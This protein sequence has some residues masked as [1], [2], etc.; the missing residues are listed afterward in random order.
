MISRE[1]IAQRLQPEGVELVVL[2][3]VE[4]RGAV[5]HVQELCLV[6]LHRRFMF[7]PCMTQP[8]PL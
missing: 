8:G 5:E 7:W 6:S 2:L 3:L 4:S 1:N